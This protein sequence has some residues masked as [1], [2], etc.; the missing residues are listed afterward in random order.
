MSQIIKIVHRF[1]SSRVLYEFEATDEQQASGLAMRAAL[2]AATAAKAYL[3]G[4]NL[5]GAYL[6]GANLGGAYLGGA[7]L[8]GANL[9]GAYL[10]GAY[11]DGANL[12]GAYLR[13][14]YLDGA[15][16]GGAYLDGAYLD[17]AYL[18]GAYLDGDAK[19]VG[20]RP[21][22]IIGPIGSRCAYFTSYITDKGLRLQAGCFFGTREEFVAKLDAEH[23]DNLHGHEYRAALALIDAHVKT[24]TPQAEEVTES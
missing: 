19:L 11:L 4:A 21:V 9:G 2:E 12:G 8:G 20:E 18:D 3:G 6:G 7:N 10:R 16:L 14:A 17:G 15:N 13:G 1:D 5:D 24:W 23:G 22:F